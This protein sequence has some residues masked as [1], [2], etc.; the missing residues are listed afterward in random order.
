MTS[1]SKGIGYFRLLSDLFFV[2]FSFF[3]AAFLSHRDIQIIDWYLS[4]LLAITWYFSSRMT[5]LYDEF[6]TSKFI[7]EFLLLFPNIIL[8]FI[9]V[10]LVFFTLNDQLFQRQLSFIYPI[11][12]F[13]FLTTT[14]YAAKKYL[15]YVRSKGR[16][17][18]KILIVGTNKL[19]QKFWEIIKHNTIFGYQLEGFIDEK[20]PAHLNGLYKGKLEDI[21]AILS[22]TKIEEIIIA[23]PEFSS[24]NLE[25]VIRVAD[26]YAV[27][28]R[29]IPDYFRFNSNRFQL[30]MFGDYPLVTVRRE[31][32][33][34]YYA[35]IMKRVFDIVFSILVIILI[36]SWLFP[37]VALLI[38]LDSK[39]PVFYK[40]ERWGKGNKVFQCFKFRSMYV[41]NDERKFKQAGIDDPRI[42]KVGKWLRKTN[43][44][45]MPQFFNVLLGDMAVV[46]P[47]PHAALHNEEAKKEIEAYLV[48]HWVKPGITG[49][50]QVNGYRGETKNNT[51][52]QKRVEFDIHYIENWTFWFDI[53]IVLM[54]IYNT[55][56]G[57]MMAY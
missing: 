29:F 14:K 51:L 32:L 52:M 16:N 4:L 41:Q 40:Q 26:K 21:D 7:D 54:T 27:R 3:L 34:Q 17:I 35:Q 19:A 10:V 22:R 48:R 28:T 5:N 33:E 9:V 47:R 39:G 45:E 6:R 50:A 12:L 38:K 11:V 55:I 25:Y 20:K 44:D 53:E 42:T 43:L 2:Y 24:A 15:Q 57:D 49:W 30:E 56:K 23:V 46:G 37:I 1:I 36:F 31:P 18:K 8:Q 13:F